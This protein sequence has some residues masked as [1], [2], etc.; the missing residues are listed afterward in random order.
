MTFASAP[1]ER[2]T[3]PMVTLLIVP[4]DVASAI[5]SAS[6]IEELAVVAQSV[7]ASSFTPGNRT[8]LDAAGVF[9]ALCR[10]LELVHDSSESAPAQRVI[11]KHLDALVMGSRAHGMVAGD[12]RARVWAPGHV[13]NPISVG[14][15]GGVLS[16]LYD[17][18]R[19]YSAASQTLSDEGRKSLRSLL[20]SI[21]SVV[22]AIVYRTEPLDVSDFDD[23]E[24]AETF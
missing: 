4:A 8:P 17:A 24:L 2:G 16:N 5:A 23:L 6:S 3:I 22:K 13:W 1:P 19:A 14:S 11:R 7:P 9:E 20:Y 15:L 18:Q 21:D 12:V 10:G